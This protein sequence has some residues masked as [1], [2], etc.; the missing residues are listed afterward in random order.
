MRSI[1]SPSWRERVQIALSPHRLAMVRLSRGLKP[2]VTDRKCLPC[3]ED[4]A[5][6]NWTAPMNALREMVIHPNVPK[7]GTTVILSNHFVRY[8]VLPWSAE[9]ITESEELE[10]ARARF[11]Q[12]FGEKARDWAI[13]ISNAPAGAG[14][15]AAATDLALIDALTRTLDGASLRLVSCQPALMAQFNGLRTRIGDDAWLVSAEQGRLLIAWI[16]KGQWRSV[17]TRP[18]NGTAAPLRELLEQERMLL[19]AGSL[20]DKVFLSVV[21]DVA[22]DTEGLRL[23]RLGPNGRVAPRVDTDFALVMAGVH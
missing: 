13:R 1:V 3:G 23:E 20:D 7:A 14:R 2:R 10:F 19:S 21:D 11:V 4:G 22:I 17:R 6:P 9:I 8:L 18:V 15:L 16:C 12:V 5:Q